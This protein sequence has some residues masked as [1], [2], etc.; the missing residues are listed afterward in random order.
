MI[1]Y[2]KGYVEEKIEELK[3]RVRNLKRTP[4]LCII[5][6]EGDAASER[7]VRNKNKRA[8]E[9]GIEHETILFP[10]DVSQEEVKNKIEELNSDD[11][12]DGI[13]LQLPLPKHLD[14]HYLMNLIV[15][16]FKKKASKFNENNIKV[17]ADRERLFPSD[18][19]SIKRLEEKYEKA[20]AEVTESYEMSAMWS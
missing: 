1:L 2:A 5:R 9:V 11:N 19:K 15:E 16:Y 7:Y 14:E 3:V 18:V 10:S 20:K 6:V 17:L 12:V 13:L 8:D 4:K